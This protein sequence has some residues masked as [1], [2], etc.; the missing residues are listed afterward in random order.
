MKNFIEVIQYI[1]AFY[2]YCVVGLCERDGIGLSGAI[3]N[4]IVTAVIMFCLQII[5]K[6]ASPINAHCAR[7][8]SRKIFFLFRHCLRN[9]LHNKKLCQRLDPQDRV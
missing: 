8:I 6:L 7:K 5:K 2:I 3:T 4:I 9:F 1:A